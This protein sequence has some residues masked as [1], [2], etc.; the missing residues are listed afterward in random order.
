ML[1]PEE[2]DPYQ[3]VMVYPK[4]KPLGKLVDLYQCFYEIFQS[5]P[6][7]I[8]AVAKHLADADDRE[9]IWPDNIIKSERTEFNAFDDYGLLMVCMKEITD[10]L[11]K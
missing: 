7:L 9:E 4:D 5:T 2:F 1:R 8:K 3:F 11:I 10:K 6:E